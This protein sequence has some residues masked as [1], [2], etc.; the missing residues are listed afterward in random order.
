[1]IKREKGLSLL[2][3][4]AIAAVLAACSANAGIAGSVF[5][6]LTPL[7]ASVKGT[8]T[9]RGGETG[10]GDQLATAIANATAEAVKVYGTQT[11]VANLNSP[12][13]LATATAIAPVVAELP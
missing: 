10:G 13:R 8:L 7:S 9:A 2:L 5:E 6:T 12:E 3:G 1:M 4:A 11:A